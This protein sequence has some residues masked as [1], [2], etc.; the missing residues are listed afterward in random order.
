[1][2]ILRFYVAYAGCHF[3]GTSQST[4]S[5]EIYYGQNFLRTLKKSMI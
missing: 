2:S 4:S 1:M 3:K 5:N